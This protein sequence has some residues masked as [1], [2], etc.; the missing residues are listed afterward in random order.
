MLHSYVHNISY[1]GNSVNCWDALRAF[2]ATTQRVISNVKAEKIKDWVI[3]S[4]A[5]QKWVE[6]S[7]T[8]ETGSKGVEYTSSEVEVP[9]RPKGRK[10]WSNLYRNIELLDMTENAGDMSISR[11]R[12]N[13]SVRI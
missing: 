9:R 6:G 1:V 7:T 10:I 3:S 4:Q 13:A 8:I 2:I 11:C 12:S 5:A